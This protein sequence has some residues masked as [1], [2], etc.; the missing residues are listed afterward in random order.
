MDFLVEHCFHCHG[1]GQL[2]HEVQEVWHQRPFAVVEGLAPDSLL[3]FILHWSRL[4]APPT[5]Q[6]PQTW[7]DSG[8][9]HKNALSFKSASHSGIPFSYRKTPKNSLQKFSFL[10]KNLILQLQNVH[11]CTQKFSK[12]STY[13]ILHLQNVLTYKQK[14]SKVSKI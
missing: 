12:L 5:Y 7:E 13:L 11:R 1:H 10:P 14:F 6:T 8:L 9:K 4:G 2:V 3:L